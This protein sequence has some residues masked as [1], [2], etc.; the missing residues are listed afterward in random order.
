MGPVHQTRPDGQH[1]PVFA[2]EYTGL[3]PAGGLGAT[4]GDCAAARKSSMGEQTVAGDADGIVVCGVR[5]IS[6][7]SRP[8]LRSRPYS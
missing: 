8:Y 3:Y 7:L 5:Y 4:A 1:F 6:A 2:V